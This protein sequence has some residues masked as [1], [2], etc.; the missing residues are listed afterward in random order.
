MI[1]LLATYKRIARV[2]L[3]IPPKVSPEARDLIIRVCLSNRSACFM[4]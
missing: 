4:A 2:D 1:V 3:K